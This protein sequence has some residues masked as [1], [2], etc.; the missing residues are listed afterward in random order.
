MK[1]P[2]F[3]FSEPEYWGPLYS[4]SS[5]SS[6][7]L[8]FRRSQVSSYSKENISLPRIGWTKRVPTRDV[9]SRPTQPAWTSMALSRPLMIQAFGFVLRALALVGSFASWS[10][11]PTSSSRATR[12]RSFSRPRTKRT[13]SQ[14]P[15]EA[16]P[17]PF[18]M[19]LSVALLIPA[20]SATISALRLR[21]SRARRIFSPRVVRVLCVEG[22]RITVFLGITSNKISDILSSVQSFTEGLNNP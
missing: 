10:A 1:S 3:G 19:A 2:K 17:D 5:G 18:S 4:F 13:C 21:L 15:I 12:V 20:R 22:R 7:R 6:T 9:L 16:D 11:L 14:A 8:S